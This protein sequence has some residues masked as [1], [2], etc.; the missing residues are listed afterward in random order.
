M[1]EHSEV[2]NQFLGMQTFIVG[3]DMKGQSLQQ[4][5]E[6]AINLAIKKAQDMSALP[7]SISASDRATIHQ[8]L[9][10]EALKK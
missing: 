10:P 5:A 2:V 7:S 4:A 6:R 8:E 1:Q 9:T 3:R